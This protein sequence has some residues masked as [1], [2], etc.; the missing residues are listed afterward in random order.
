MKPHTFIAILTTIFYQKNVRFT[1]AR[2]KDRCPTTG[3]VTVPQPESET[4]LVVG[5]KLLLILHTDKTN[6]LIRKF[7]PYNMYMSIF[8]I[9]SHEKLTKYHFE[10]VFDEI[11][12]PIFLHNVCNHYKKRTYWA[13]NHVESLITDRKQH[14]STSFDVTSTGESKLSTVPQPEPSHNR[15]LSPTGWVIS[16]CWSNV[17][18]SLSFGFLF[19][20]RN[21]IWKKGIKFV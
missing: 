4:I 18:K 21:K 3:Y 15:R 9:F 7:S 1:I 14:I 8:L 2:Q 11:F 17:M 10:K 20:C 12:F 6:L 5:R 19:V 13:Q 16:F